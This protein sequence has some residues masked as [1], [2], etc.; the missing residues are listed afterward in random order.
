MVGMES[1]DPLTAAHDHSF[2]NRSEITQSDT[3]GCYCCLAI[4]PPADVREWLTESDGQESAFCPRCSIDAVIGSA[5]GF[6]ITSEFLQKMRR[7]WFAGM[8]DVPPEFFK[9]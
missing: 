9:K 6:P 5:S 7:R 2:K 4:F 1:V 8:A 3:C